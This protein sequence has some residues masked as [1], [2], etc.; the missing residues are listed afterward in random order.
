MLVNPGKLKA[1][2]E[3]ESNTWNTWNQFRSL[4][5]AVCVSLILG[6]NLPG[7]VSSSFKLNDFTLG[8]VNRIQIMCRVWNSLLIVRISLFMTNK[9]FS[10]VFQDKTLFLRVS[11]EIIA[12]ANLQKH[13]MICKTCLCISIVVGDLVTFMFQWDLDSHEHSVTSCSGQQVVVLWA[14]GPLNDFPSSS[15]LLHVQEHSFYYFPELLHYF[16]FHFRTWQTQTN[17]IILG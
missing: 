6:L 5:S 17:R 16:T 9:T 14:V 1:F 10:K 12:L 4:T 13:L 15:P 11:L 8:K 7:Q 3:E 2:F